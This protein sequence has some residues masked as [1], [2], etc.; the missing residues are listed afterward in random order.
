MRKTKT[1]SLLFLLLLVTGKLNAQDNIPY[2]SPGITLGWNS[3]G[4]ISISPK[5]SLG[6][7]WNG[8]IYTNITIG[9]MATFSK[10]KYNYEYCELQAGS[11]RHFISGG[12]GFAITHRDNNREVV[13]KLSLSAGF[14]LFANL[15]MA[16]HPDSV[17]TNWG[18]QGVFPIILNKQFHLN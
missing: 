3:N 2:L 12:A 17:N 7:I 9:A 11:I 15:D 18:I 10:A 4:A 1:I 6:V 16:V 5:I 14:L 13:P 8:G